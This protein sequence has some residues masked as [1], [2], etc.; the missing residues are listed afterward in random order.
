MNTVFDNPGVALRTD[1]LIALRQMALFSMKTS[2]LSSLPGGFAVRRKGRGLEVADTREYVAGD[3]IRHLDRGTTARTGKL[4]VRQFQEE[5][6]RTMLLVADF[7]QAMFWGLRRVFRSVSA[8]EILALL[9]WSGVA[10]GGRVGLLAITPSEVITVPARGRTRGML[11][12]IGGLVRAHQAG[13]SDVLNGK[14]EEPQLDAALLS[15][16]R[17][18]PPGGELIIASGF[19]DAGPGLADRLNA[20][21]LRRSPKLVFVT[22]AEWEDL[23]SGRYPIRLSNGH[24]IQLRIGR[25][26][27]ASETSDSLQIAGQS[28]LVVN[29]SDEIET[30][31]R[32]VF[33]VFQSRSAA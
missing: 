4:H 13:L 12:V 5:R 18:V 25:D 11:D 23:P 19:D 7:R 8:A 1:D 31:A 9:G 26:N 27:A 2:S 17:L 21:A 33:G 3:E 22:D 15:A 28:A 30:T 10:Q 14:S 29:A 20:I 32:R 6:D 16:E 24:F